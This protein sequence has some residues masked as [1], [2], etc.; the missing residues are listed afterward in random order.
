MTRSVKDKNYTVLIAED[1]VPNQLL[2]KAYVQSY[3][4]QAI[5]ANDGYEA[6]A[7]FKKNKFD[8]CIIDVKMPHMNGLD[9]TKQI[10]A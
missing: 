4:W 6:V 9:A 1:S 2:L 7:M 3:G 5:C 8:V 10:R